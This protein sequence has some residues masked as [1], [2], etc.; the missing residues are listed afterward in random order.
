MKKNY[1]YILIII[2]VFGCNSSYD[3]NKSIFSIAT[4]ATPA[5]LEEIGFMIT[6]DMNAKGENI[7]YGNMNNADY[8]VSVGYLKGEPNKMTHLGI[9]INKDVFF[10]MTKLKPMDYD[11]VEIDHAFFKVIN[12]HPEGSLF[13]SR[14]GL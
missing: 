12:D 5:E 6:K 4:D 2:S 8:Y 7:W 1:L 9:T 11:S 13:V 10:K 3:G 14:L